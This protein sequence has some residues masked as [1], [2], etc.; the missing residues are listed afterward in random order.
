VV[1]TETTVDR[2]PQRRT[3][4]T[5]GLKAKEGGRRWEGSEEGVKSICELWTF[6]I[7]FFHVDW[8]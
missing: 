5:I 8:T 1:A 7:S 2:V 4:Q 6:I 3:I